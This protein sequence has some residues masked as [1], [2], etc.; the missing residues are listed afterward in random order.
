MLIKAR[1]YFPEIFFGMLLAIA[2][3]AL[4]F[5]FASSGCFSPTQQITANHTDDKKPDSQKGKSLWIPEDSTGFFTLWVALFTGIL[6]LSTIKLYGA[7]RDSAAAAQKQATISANVEGPL[8]VVAALKLV[9][10]QQIPGEVV[11]ADPLPPGPIQANCRI[12]LLIENKGRTPLRC[13]ELCL[14]K[15]V[16]NSLPNQPTYTHIAP[17]G[18]VLEKGPIWIR[19]TEE[20]GDVTQ[21]DVQAAAA[22]YPNGAFWVF[23]YFAYWNLLNEKT[24]HKFAARWDLTQGFVR[25]DRAGY[26]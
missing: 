13:I 11:V 1:F 22:A 5:V 23:G 12:L 25:E 17:W 4:G 16:G 7:T 10:Y 2:L 15:H 14:E 21:A 18:L 8:P 19:F 24:V 6:A 9:Q 3:I 20:Q 26:T